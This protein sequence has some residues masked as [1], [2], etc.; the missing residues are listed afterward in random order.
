MIT[1]RPQKNL[2]TAKEY[3]R[4]H[5]SQGDYYSEGQSVA[6][7]W[8]GHGIGRLGLDSSSPVTETAFIRLCDNEHPATG[9]R[10]TVRHRQQ[11]RRVF[12]DFAVSAP[13]SVSVLALTVGDPRLINA[14]EEAARAAFSRVER[15]AATRV[16]KG[17]SHA[18][19]H[20]GEIVAAEFRHDT[21]R[22]L[23]PQLHSHFVVFNGTWDP[24][25]SRWKA[26]QTSK[27]FDQMAFFTEV[28]R[29]ELALRAR[30]LGY[31]IRNTANGFEIDGVPQDILDRFSKR[32]RDILAAEPQAVA[33]LNA[34]RQRELEEAVQES[35]TP[36]ARA[37]AE[38]ARRNFLPLTALTNTGRSHLAH[39]TRPRKSD[40]LKAEEV[41]AYQQGQLTPEELAALRRLVSPGEAP[42]HA[43]L[44]PAF[45]LAPAILPASALIPT[46]GPAEAIDYAR[47]HLFERRSVV[48][49]CHILTEAMAYT[50]GFVT[51]LELE[52]DLARRQEFIAVDEMLTTEGTLRQEQ[53]LLK[54]VNQG[55]GRVR[56]LNAAFVGDAKLTREQ[57]L[58][59]RHI[60]C[61]PDLV[62]GLRGGA[63]T[64]KST[65]LRE[66]LKGIEERQVAIILAP[67]TAAVESLR[68]EGLPRTATVQRFLADPEFQASAQGQVL[69]VDEAGLLST[70]D[71][72]P[73]VEFVHAHQGRLILSGDT[74][75]HTGVEAGDA[76]RLLERQSALRMAGVQGIRRQSERE[77]RAAIGELAEGKGSEALA[78]LDRLGALHE[79][80]EE[81]RYPLLASEY[82]NSLKANK[83]ALVVSPTWREISRVTQEVRTQLKAAGLLAREETELTVHH[84]S[85]WTRAQKRDLRNY[86]AKMVLTFHK[87]AKEFVAGEWA[88]VVKVEPDA[89]AVRKRNGQMVT[90]TKKQ[91]GC[92]DVA[93][94]VKLPVAPG[95]RLLIQSNRKPD[96][97]FNGQIVTVR[98]VKADGRV[99]LTDGRSIAPDFR[100]FTHGYCVTSHGSQGRTVDHVYVAVDSASAQAANLNQFYVSASR[101]REQVKVFTDD[102]EFLRQAVTRSAARLSATDLLERARVAQRE[103]IKERPVLNPRL[104]V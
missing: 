50:R 83:S 44:I 16:G 20:T 91:V 59:L 97:L 36:E 2:Q 46:I 22:A 102:I 8:F 29:S 99:L 65:L 103:E 95:E 66:V 25:E 94:R 24:V 21:S 11:D 104:A 56:P 9:E 77:Y 23:D 39:A 7:R 4:K 82:V 47:D 48:P 69:V 88:E 42:R 68:K 53:R 1:A 31:G 12:Y 98:Q 92:F 78:R 10:L 35:Q 33:E 67:T 28:Y 14:H 76:L 3:F 41:L 5:L 62:L 37:A 73:L 64:G 19:R 54:L 63:G 26:L 32:R 43:S 55:V 49:R 84:A 75:Q 71:L 58:A 61:S 40:H 93:V 80:D 34:R 30:A 45:N 6:G 89:L 51:L 52:T 13:K 38:Q 74:R 17:G 70:K 72:L 86:Q 96:G 60:L 27:M 101:G 79:A 87:G 18:D 81:T 90:V 85:K 15:V 100:A 57:R